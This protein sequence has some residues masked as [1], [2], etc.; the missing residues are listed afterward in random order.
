MIIFLFFLVLKLIK[1]KKCEIA[2]TGVLKGVKL[3]LCSMK[4][5]NLN[6]D[7]IKIHGLCYS[8]HKK[9]ENEKNFLNHIKK[10]QNVLNMWR[11]RNVSFL[12]NIS[13]FNT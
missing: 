2:D 6:N 12:G 7:V 9:L 11:I 13:I 5:V 8:Y 1:K 3:A 4:C 10:F